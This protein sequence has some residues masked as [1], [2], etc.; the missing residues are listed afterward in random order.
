[1][2]PGK[3]A[4]GGVIQGGGARGTDEIPAI[5]S[6][7]CYPESFQRALGDK[8]CEALN[9]SGGLQATETATAD[10]AR[11]AVR[12]CD[13]PGCTGEDAC[14][15]LAH[16]PEPLGYWAAWDLS[17]EGVPEERADRQMVATL[18]EWL[19]ID[20]RTGTGEFIVHKRDEP[21]STHSGALPKGERIYSAR[22]CGTAVG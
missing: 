3:L 16:G 15:R 5:L 11:L 21:E 7:G 2:K 19:A 8:A 22:Y 9:Q 6:R 4:P 18:T 12:L 20:P 10:A 13:D 17:I 1:M 14:P